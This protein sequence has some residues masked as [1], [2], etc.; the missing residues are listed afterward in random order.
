MSAQGA[1][2]GPA[3]PGDRTGPGSAVVRDDPDGIVR[4]SAGPVC[5]HDIRTCAG[6]GAPGTGK[7]RKTLSRGANCFYRP[8]ETVLLKEFTYSPIPSYRK[9]AFPRRM[10]LPGQETAERLPDP[11]TPDR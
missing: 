5:G 9:H 3:F 1:G 2:Q 10:N 11:Q 4:A 7:P 8:W 6:N